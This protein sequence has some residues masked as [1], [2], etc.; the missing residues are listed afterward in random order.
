M[1][2]IK[3]LNPLGFAK[4]TCLL[5][6]IP[7][8]IVLIFGIIAFMLSYSP[9]YSNRNVFSELAL[10]IGTCLV[11]ALGSFAWGYLS[12]LVYN[13]VS[14]RIGGISL[15]LEKGMTGEYYE[16]KKLSVVK[17]AKYVAIFVFI[18]SLIGWLIMLI[19]WF[20]VE[21]EFGSYFSSYML[22]D[23]LIVPGIA[24]LANVIVA[25]VGSL[26]AG[27]YY[28]WLAMK[29]KGYDIRL[30]YLSAEDSYVLTKFRVISFCTVSGLLE[31]VMYLVVMVVY[32]IVMALL[33]TI[34][35]GGG[36]QYFITGFIED[37]RRE[38]LIIPLTVLLG[39]MLL[40]FVITFIVAA[41]FSGLYNALSKRMEMMKFQLIKSE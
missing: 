14:N 40:A 16:V 21:A 22:D 6:V 34:F 37:V 36:I 12:A 23:I 20:I 31:A 41:I 9:Y 5:G 24:V 15:A 19:Y 39:G 7:I 17:F 4:T 8:G 10:F 26:I 35:G 18:A 27:S 28:N 1:Y 33:T 3:K 30:Q 25:F 11:S 29:G 32:F 2:E 38:Y 13:F